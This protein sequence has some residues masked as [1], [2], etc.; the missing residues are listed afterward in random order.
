[1]ASS[2]WQKSLETRYKGNKVTLEGPVKKRKRGKEKQK[3]EIN[4]YYLYHV[5]NSLGKKSSK[6][7]GILIGQTNSFGTTP[8]MLDSK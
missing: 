8:S 1:M 6:N 4:K 7:N 3:L 5:T 2:L